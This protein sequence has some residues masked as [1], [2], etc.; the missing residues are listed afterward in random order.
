MRR[1]T[2]SKLSL[3]IFARVGSNARRRV[4][5]ESDAVTA[6]GLC[7]LTSDEVNGK[8]GLLLKARMIQVYER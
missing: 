4:L 3:Y 7:G 1:T 6:R 2:A 5:E 8:T